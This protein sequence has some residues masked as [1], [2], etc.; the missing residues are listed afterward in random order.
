MENF[1]QNLFSME[2]IP[3][4]ENNSH[5]N[6]KYETNSE[7]KREKNVLRT[8]QNWRRRGDQLENFLS[9]HFYLKTSLFGL[10]EMFLSVN[11][12]HKHFY[13][14]TKLSQLYWIMQTRQATPFQLI[15]IDSLGTLDSIHCGV[16]I[17]K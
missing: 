3:L 1:S 9:K 11:P 14:F 12:P 8:F 15:F 17:D 10:K 13:P 4:L 2:T 16:P 7:L 6:S 5:K